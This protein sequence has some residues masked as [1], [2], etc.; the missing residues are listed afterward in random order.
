[1]QGWHKKYRNNKRLLH[2]PYQK[3]LSFIVI[4]SFCALYGVHV[5]HANWKP[6]DIHAG[7][8]PYFCNPGACLLAACSWQFLTCQ[9]KRSN[10][11]LNYFSQSL[12]FMRYCC[13]RRR[14]RNIENANVIFCGTAYFCLE[15]RS[16]LSGILPTLRHVQAFI[17]VIS[18]TQ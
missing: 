16:V 18:R 5:V 9:L 7:I 14:R 1:M 8:K 15:V 3:F 6:Q 4:Y 2:A 10:S 13:Q 12:W 17:A 11:V